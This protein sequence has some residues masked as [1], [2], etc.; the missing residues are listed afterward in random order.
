MRIGVSIL[1]NGMQFSVD[2][3]NGQKTG[4]YLDQR[5]NRGLIH[6]YAHGKNVLNCFSYTGAFTVYALRAGAE[7]V[8]SIDSSADANLQAIKHLQIND[9]PESGAQMITGDVFAELR[10]MRDKAQSY[11][12]IILD[13]PKFA[14]TCCAQVRSA[15]RG[16]KDI[17]LLAFKAA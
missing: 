13:P 8:V 17:N 10:L 5:L 6:K 9:L 11:D 16:Y 2:I 7:Q 3:Q 12:L 14:P 1:E 4:F 15:A